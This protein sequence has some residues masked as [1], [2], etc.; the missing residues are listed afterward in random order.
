[1]ATAEGR[2]RLG[3]QLQRP[4]VFANQVH[5]VRIEWWPGE[6]GA[7]A[8]AGPNGPEP[9]AYPTCDGLISGQRG[10]GLVI[11]TA[12]CLPVL[13]ADPE[14]NLVAA[15]HAGWRGLLDGVIAA[16]LAELE[17]AGARKPRAAIGPSIC[18]KCYEIGDDLAE[19]AGGQ[20]RVVRRDQRGRALLDLADSAGRELE[21]AGVEV[22]WRSGECTAESGELFS[23]RAD[24]STGRQGGVIGLAS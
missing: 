23:W 9:A 14:R 12:D 16:G 1:L 2:E 19:L 20:G 17:R 24:R 21:Q 18:G 11:R 3:E 8:V 10:I 7:Q 13:L 5:G 4:L 22:I 15:I 6:P